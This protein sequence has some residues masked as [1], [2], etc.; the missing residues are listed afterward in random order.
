M[1]SMCNFEFEN[2]K[3][4]FCLIVRWHL[5]EDFET[6]QSKLSV[7]FDSTA[8]ARETLCRHSRSVDVPLP[9]LG[10]PAATK[11]AHAQG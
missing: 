2:V 1:L 7:L 6:K 11:S 5:A 4:H 8:L 3:F 9:G 10:H